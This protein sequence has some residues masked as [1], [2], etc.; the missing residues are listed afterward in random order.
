MTQRADRLGITA[1]SNPVYVFEYLN[2]IETNIGRL[3][4][5][6]DPDKND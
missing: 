5:E 4:E 6:L 3:S 1:T 2:T